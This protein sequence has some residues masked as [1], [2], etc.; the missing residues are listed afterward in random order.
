MRVPE[1]KVAGS[2]VVTSPAFADG[3][4]IPREFTCYGA[5][6]PPEL[7]WRGVPPDATSLA[8]VVSDPD[9]PRGTFIHWVLYDLPPVDGVLASGELPPGAREAQNSAGTTGLYP[10]CP[11]SGTHRYLFTV[12]ALS[13]PASGR[14]TQDILD[15]LGRKAVAR[16]TLTGL[17]SAR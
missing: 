9:A 5:G 13:E 12:Y 17:V 10:P 8:V 2:I 4:P 1:P 3:Q 11:P 15:E 14:S 7:V 16:G 6:R